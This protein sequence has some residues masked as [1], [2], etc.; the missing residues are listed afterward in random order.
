M[1]AVTAVPLRPLAKGSV[2]RLWIG[3]ALLVALAAGLAWWSTRWLQPV[4]LESGVR[5]QTIR[6]GNGAAMTAADVIAM[7]F[8]IKVNSRDAVAFRDSGPQP[9]VGTVQDLPAGFAE[10]VQRMRAGG[11]YVVSAPVS[12]VMAGQPVPPSA[13]FTAGDTLL[14]ETQVLQIDPG[15]ASAY[16]MRRI[17]QLMQQQQLMQGGPGGPGAPPPGAAPSAPPASAPPAAPGR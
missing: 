10:G 15:Q 12:V 7:R 3:V 14:F 2:L 1:S 4:T 16:Q 13:E 17:Q 8:Q 5:I 6:E 9:F 11:Q